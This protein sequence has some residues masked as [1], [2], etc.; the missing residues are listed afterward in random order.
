MEQTS[1]KRRYQQPYEGLAQTELM[2]VRRFKS[3]EP[4]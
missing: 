1:Q 4:P 3:F 2:L